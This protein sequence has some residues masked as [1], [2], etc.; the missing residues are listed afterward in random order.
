MVSDYSS[1]PKEG[2]ISAMTRHVHTISA[3]LFY[4][5]GA[6]FFGAYLLLRNEIAGGWPVW[7]MSVAD[8]PLAIVCTLY[9]GTSLYL[10]L[11]K[12][13]PSKSLAI[14]I[15]I[16]LIALLVFLFVLNFWNVLGL[17][18]AEY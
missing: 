4:L 9:G 11:R 18:I 10:S 16:P 7:W 14:V 6:S 3:V 5:L 1:P 17:P 15:A 12:E 8:L 2:T 13:K